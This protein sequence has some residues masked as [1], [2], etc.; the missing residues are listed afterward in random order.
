[1]KITLDLPEDLLNKAMKISR[2]N[3]KTAV[4]VLALNDWLG[5]Q[6]FRN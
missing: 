3:T 1:M 2:T 5:K 6:K 4:V